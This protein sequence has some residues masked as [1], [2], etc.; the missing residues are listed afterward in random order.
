M[1]SLVIAS[2]HAAFELKEA[3][4]AK[5][6]SSGYQLE[7]LG[8]YSTE[9]VHYPEYAKKL[10]E[11]VVE[12]KCRGILLCGSGIGVSIAA[13]RYP[14]IYA[15]L[16]TN[17]EMAQMSRR[18]NHAN[19]LVMGSRFTEQKLAEEILDAWLS[20]EPELGRHEAR[21]A[22]IDAHMNKVG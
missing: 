12:H 16:V 8:C 22:M 9:S 5:L 1:E 13:N 19:V 21:V 20:T 11:Y 2:D 6:I 7:D 3:L 14:G 10:A 15:A 17:V 18:H 4:K